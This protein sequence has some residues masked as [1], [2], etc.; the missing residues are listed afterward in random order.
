MI[1]DTFA[2]Q[3]IKVRNPLQ[4]RYPSSYMS[5]VERTAFKEFCGVHKSGHN[6]TLEIVSL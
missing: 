5:L 6:Y 1:S 4:A 3:D 2:M